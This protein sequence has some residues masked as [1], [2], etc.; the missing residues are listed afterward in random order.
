[1]H[2]C[3]GCATSD[4]TAGWMPARYTIAELNCLDHSNAFATPNLPLIQRIRSR[5]FPF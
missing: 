4:V 1:V 5:T 3:R 2:G